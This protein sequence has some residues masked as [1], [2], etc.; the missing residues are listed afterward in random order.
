MLTNE[1]YYSKEVSKHYMSS[2]Q[3]KT[4]T[5]CE[6]M[7]LAEVNGDFERER[8]TAM[9]IGG[10]VDSHF[11]G[12]LDLFRAKN[13]E[14]MTQKGELKAE[15]KHANYIIERIERD[16]MFMKYLN[17]EVQK[18]ILGEIDGVPFRGKLDVLHPGKAIVDL[19]VM[20]SMEREWKDGLKL[21]FVE[22]WNYDTQLAIYQHLE[23]NKLP[24]FIAAAT[25][26]KEPDLAIINIPQERLDYCLSLVKQSVKRY[27]ELKQGIGEPTR[28]EKCDYCK[29]TRVLT[30]IISYEDVGK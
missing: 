20:R 30:Q 25:K 18:I 2:S 29:R 5:Q 6:A 10:Y 26:E 28:C 21:S 27:H 9:L 12:T 8:N 15:F 13:P 16:E 24:V 11:E 22:Y 3:F 19:K 17:G 14:I 1:N 23:G 4:F 7:A